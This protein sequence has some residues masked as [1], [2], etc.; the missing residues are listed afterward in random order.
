MNVIYA[1]VSTGDQAERQTIAAQLHACSEWAA[2]K[3]YAVGE[4]F[5]DEGASGSVPFAE[6]PEGWRLLQ[7]A[8]AGLVNRIIVYCPDRL[9]RDVYEALA[10]MRE[11][12]RLKVDVD[13]V[14]QSFD[15][16]PEGV[17]QFQVLL[18]VAEFERKNIARRTHQGRLRRV[19]E[20]RYMASIT[21]YGYDYDA[22]TGELTVNEEQAEVVRQIFRWARDGLGLHAIASRLEAGGIPLPIRARGKQKPKKKEWHTTTLW[23]MLTHPR[24]TGRATYAGQSMKCPSIVDSETFQA[25]QDALRERRGRGKPGK[26]VRFYLLR[27]LVYCRECGSTAGGITARKPN[28]W[29]KSDYRC[30]QAK[31]YKAA[32][33]KHVRI[34]WSADETEN[35]VKQFIVN[36]LAEPEKALATAEIAT[37]EA[38]QAR[39]EARRTRTRA[40]AELD[41][42]DSEE[43]YVITEARKRYISEMAMLQQLDQINARRAELEEI[44]SQQEPQGAV[45]S[46]EVLAEVLG[47]ASETL[48][49]W[50]VDTGGF[51]DDESLI[52]KLVSRVWLEPD[53]TVTVE[54]VLTISDPAEQVEPSSPRS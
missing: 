30:Q 11:F 24:Y 29:Q 10:A 34:R 47:K 21:P 14:V 48:K 35:A 15:D 8:E 46:P 23:K 22:E 41:G 50:I 31:R 7:M 39:Q 5:K 1:R 12:K 51:V 19:R 17:L 2:S 13:F 4:E 40:Q 43:Q 9:G 6:R 49:L 37:H 52:H 26:Q 18:A 53:G 54:G 38:A 32:R 36:L 16:T 20:G 45:I 33:A 44:L 42:L 27:G 28:G 25:V 3:D